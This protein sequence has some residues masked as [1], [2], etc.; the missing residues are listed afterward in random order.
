MIVAKYL[1]HKDNAGSRC[2][3]LP[4][5]RI[6]SD[7]MTSQSILSWREKK[8]ACYA[9]AAWR[10]AAAIAVTDASHCQ[11]RA[12]GERGWGL[13]ERIVFVRFAQ[14]VML[15]AAR[16]E[17]HPEHHAPWWHCRDPDE[18]SDRSTAAMASAALMFSFVT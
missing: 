15:A 18:N 5:R 17:P 2:N 12:I 10:P 7:M 9:P 8:P 6:S 3:L 14:R 16:I 4:C 11:V 13:F 1:Q